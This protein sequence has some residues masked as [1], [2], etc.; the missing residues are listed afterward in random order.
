M[1]APQLS[2]PPRGNGRQVRAP[3]RPRAARCPR[4]LLLVPAGVL[5]GAAAV[6]VLAV[7]GLLAARRSTTTTTTSV[8]Q[9][10]A[11]RTATAGGARCSG[12]LSAATNAGVVTFRSRPR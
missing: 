12:A 4:A 10:P 3:P 2:S 8:Q 5:G 11:A 6:G 9:P 7:P 1:S